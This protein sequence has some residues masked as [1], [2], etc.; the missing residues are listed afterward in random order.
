MS[1]TVGGGEVV[2][3]DLVFLHKGHDKLILSGTQYNATQWH[4]IGGVQNED[5]W[6]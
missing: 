1:S 6:V 3:A 4:G 2:P 5:V